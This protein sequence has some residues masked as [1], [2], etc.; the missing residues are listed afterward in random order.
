MTFSRSVLKGT[1]SVISARCIRSTIVALRMVSE[2]SFSFG[3]TILESSS[4]R[5]NVYVS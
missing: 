3:I 4:A 5:R 2:A 1:C